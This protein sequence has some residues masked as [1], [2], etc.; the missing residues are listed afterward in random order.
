MHNKNTNWNELPAYM[1]SQLG[2]H[3]VC[4]IINDEYKFRSK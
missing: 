2:P 1:I 4:V 3:L